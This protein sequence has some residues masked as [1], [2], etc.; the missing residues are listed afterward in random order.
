MLETLNGPCIQLCGHWGR[1]YLEFATKVIVCFLPKS[2]M[3]N[4]EYQNLNKLVQEK[5]VNNGPNSLYQLTA[6]P[7]TLHEISQSRGYGKE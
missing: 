3:R 6:Q 7:K 1:I 4:L 2:N 5:L